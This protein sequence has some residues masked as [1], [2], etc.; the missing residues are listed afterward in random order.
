MTEPSK[1]MQQPTGMHLAQLNIARALDDM[2]S[3]RLADFMSASDRVNAVAERSP[4]F[5]WRLQSDTGNATDIQTSDDARLIVNL[6]VWETPAHLEHFVWNTIHKRVYEKKSKWFEAPTLAH[7]AMWWVPI[8]HR[9]TPA[10][11]LARLANLNENG[12]T[13]GAFGW[14][15]L[16]NIKLWMSQRCA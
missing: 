5:V 6:S 4:G 12:P 15:S 16:P 14:E 10:E 2:D 13:I 1:T 8:D 11:A 3:P 7:F 9:P